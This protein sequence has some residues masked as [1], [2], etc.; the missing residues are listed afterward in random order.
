M[1]TARDIMTSTIISVTPETSIQEAAQIFIDK[2]I[3]G[4]PVLDETGNLF[5]IVTENDLLFQNKRI[6]APA[7]VTI[8]DSFFFLDS[9]EKMNREI[10]KIGATFVK[11]I[12]SRPVVTVTTDTLLDEIATLMIEQNV[13]TLPVLDDNGT[14]VGIIGKKDIIRTIIL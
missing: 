7:V 1:K 2:D 9:P 4:L 13:H 6:K 12:C 11:D 8:L 14:M 5:G 3:N 10:Q